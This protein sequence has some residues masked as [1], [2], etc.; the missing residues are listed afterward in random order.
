MGL[1][2]G[3]MGSVYDK[4][5]R[6]LGMSSSMVL[7]GAAF[8]T[9]IGALLALASARSNIRHAVLTRDGHHVR[10]YPY[11][12]FYGAVSHTVH[13]CDSSLLMCSDSLW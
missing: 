8:F 7:R 3:L 2:T 9:G 5:D 11:G 13:A 6:V 10:L 1:Y 12:P 4:F